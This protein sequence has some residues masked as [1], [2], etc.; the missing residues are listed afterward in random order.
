MRALGTGV[1]GLFL[2]AA[3]GPVDPAPA[4]PGGGGG[5]GGRVI[6][7]GGDDGAGTSGDD[8]AGSFGDDGAGSFG[9]DGAG[10]FGD[11][12]PA[13]PPPTTTAGGPG[14]DAGAML[15]EHNRYRAAHCAPALT[16][17]DKL[18]GVA[19]AWA[20]H[21]RDDGC[22]FEHSRT[23]YGENLAAGTTGA[24]PPADV[25]AMWYRERD[26]YD[27]ARGGFSGKTGH[28][29]QVVWAETTAVGCGMSQC[30][31]LDVWVCNY[32]PPGNVDGGY[33]DNVK[34]TSC[35]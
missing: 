12:G 32:D 8:G 22:A 30:D 26:A 10:S 3:C 14:G 18:A 25:V 9:D 11:D 7:S 28:F 21:L 33:R 4:T 15:A 16:W 23:R 27:F 1:L 31:G 29:T 35:K 20:D 2:V 24:L 19:Q 34:P 13:P 6:S 5:G 17:S